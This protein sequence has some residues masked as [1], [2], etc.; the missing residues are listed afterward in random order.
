MT[1]YTYEDLAKDIAALTP[2]QRT[3]P[4]RCLE[5]YD[6]PACLEVS[7]VEI[8]KEDITVD[9]EVVLREGEAHLCV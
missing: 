5:P 4:V 6:D 8:A 3:Q 7:G 2:E 9:G 1:A